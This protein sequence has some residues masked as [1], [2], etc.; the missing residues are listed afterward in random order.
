MRPSGWIF[1]VVVWT[2]ILSFF[3]YCL[4]LTLRQKK[5]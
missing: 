3:L 4:S 2:G 1:L 5:N